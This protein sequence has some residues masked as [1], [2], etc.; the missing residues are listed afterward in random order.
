M[1]SESSLQISVKELPVAKILYSFIMK[2]N[3]DNKNIKKMEKYL[4]P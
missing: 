4:T 3:K 2:K 1:F